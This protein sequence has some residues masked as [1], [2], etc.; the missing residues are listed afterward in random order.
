MR[1][2]QIH[3]R[4]QYRG[5]EDYVFESEADLLREHGHHV[6][7]LLFDNNKIKTWKDKLSAATGVVYNRSSRKIV[8]EKIT[9]FRPDVIHVH[10]FIVLASPSIF[11]AARKHGIPVILTLHNFRLI[12][13]SATLYFRNGIY[14]RSIRSVLPIDAI[15]KG[16]YR[17]SRWQTAA[18]ATMTFFH[19]VTGTWKRRIDRYIALTEFARNKFERSALGIPPHKFALKPNFVKDYGTGEPSRAD[20]FLYA[21]RLTPEKGIQTLLKAASSGEFSLTIVGGGPLE[22]EVENAARRFS[23]VRYLGFQDKTQVVSLLKKCRALIFCSTWFEGLPITILEAFCTGTPVIASKLGSMAE[24]VTD[25]I[26]GLHFRAG[27]A[28]DLCRAI[29]H[30]AKDPALAETLSRNARSTYLRDY[31]PETNYAL[32]LRLYEEAVATHALPPGIR[33]ENT[34][35]QCGLPAQ[36]ENRIASEQQAWPLVTIGIPTF[37]GGARLA[38]ALESIAGQGYPNLE[39]LISNNASTDNTG[40]V[41][42]DVLKRYRQAKYYHH[43][44]NIGMLANFEFLLR[45]A[46]GKYFMWLADDDTLATDALR[47]YVRYLE[48]NPGHSLVSGKI[49]YGLNGNVSVVEEGFSFHQKSR[50]FRVIAFYSKVIYGGVFHG[51]MHTQ[52][53]RGIRMRRA[54]GSDW[55]F[56][57]ALAFSGKITQLDFTGYRK[58]FG[59]SS[60]DFERYARLIGD[61][62]FAGKYPYLKIPIDAFREIAFGPSIYSSA[63]HTERLLL[64]ILAF[65]VAWAGY[66]LRIY[67]FVIGGRIKRLLRAALT[68]KGRAD[69]KR[70]LLAKKLP[71]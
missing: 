12:C 35:F 43:E 39:I 63:S 29:N 13:P 68:P 46:K 18:I 49:E 36:P 58:N 24:I 32:L 66:Y 71:Q 56:V 55:H 67:P 2:L 15:W 10:N 31:T 50:M 47:R 3:N 30:L 17:D 69:D 54:I 51:L 7:Q 48:D 64:G 62:A 20:F 45:H 61:S 21:G 28:K 8:E 52:I 33:P 42:L 27:D 60:R 38:K 26:N 4:Y 23:N 40:W 1:I 34:K 57:A 25:H 41:C 16:V 65:V 19:H 53:A 70:G 6:E 59:G 5:G 11:F 14:E 44:K 9:S 22:A 37:N